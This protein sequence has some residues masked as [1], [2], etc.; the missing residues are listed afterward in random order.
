MAGISTGAFYLFFPSKE[1]LFVETAN[2]F[3]DKLITL[4]NESVPQK[5]SKDDLVK[6][7]KT[8]FAK[9]S[10]NKWIFSL[11]EDYELIMRK[12]PEGYLA[13]EYIKDLL[14]TS[15]ILKLYGIKPKVS[16]EEINA[17]FDILFLSYYFT[18]TVGEYHQRAL[19]LM[20]ESIA[21]NLFE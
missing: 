19:E 2:N 11:R 7:L 8:V 14:N 9:L 17:I 10:N 20:L 21:E 1:V 13:N 6:I 3:T 18:D 15:T 5:P 12:L 4:I 16:T